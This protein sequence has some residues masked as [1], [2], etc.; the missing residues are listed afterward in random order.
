MQLPE[1]RGLPT[2]SEGEGSPVEPAIRTKKGFDINLTKMKRMVIQAPMRPRM[3]DFLPI[4]SKV[5]QKV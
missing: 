5:I 3:Q 4:L 2:D 1:K